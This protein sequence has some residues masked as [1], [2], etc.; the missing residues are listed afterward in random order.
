MKARVSVRGLRKR[1]VDNSIEAYIMALETINR[2]TIKYR[3]EAFAYLICNG[4]ELLLKAKIYNDAKDRAAI[5]YPRKRGEPLR[6]LSLRDCVKRV[7]QN[8]ND[9]TR[10]NIERVAELRDEAVHLVISKVPKDVLVLFQACVLNYHKRLFEWFGISLSQR[11]S[12]GM[13]TIVYD[14]SPE[15]FDLQNPVL[16]RQLGR[17][18]VKY[19]TKLQAELREEFEALGKPAE[20]SIDL[21]YKLALTKHPTDADIILGKSASGRMTHTV[22]VPKD[23][24]KTHP[25]YVTDVVKQLQAALSGTESINRFDVQCIIE[26]YGIRNRPEF[27]YKGALRHSLGQYSQSF[28]SWI[29]TQYKNNKQFFNSTRLTKQRKGA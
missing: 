17:E 15:E 21:G 18:T 20:F 9:A 12:V 22:E 25:L 7:F 11:V 28:V 3:I 10:R 2:L 29:L 27:Y 16:R 19:L 26:V 14:F 1:L 4:W 24:S 13:M 6:S 5:Y 8:E 23:A